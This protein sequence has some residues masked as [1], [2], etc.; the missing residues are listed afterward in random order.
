MTNIRIRFFDDLTTIS[1]NGDNKDTE[2]NHVDFFKFK[3]DEH[4]KLYK[5]WHHQDLYMVQKRRFLL[6]QSALELFYTTRK[7]VMFYFEK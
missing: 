2:N 6:K 7:S 5:A 1:K 4:K 3:K